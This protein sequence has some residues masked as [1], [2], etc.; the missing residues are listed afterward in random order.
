MAKSSKQIV[1]TSSIFMVMTVIYWHISYNTLND[2]F[3]SFIS[4]Y[5]ILFAFFIVLIK[6]ESNFNRLLSFAIFS[7]I[8]VLFSIPEL[9]PDFF[10]FIWDG[11]LLTNGINPYAHL[12][13]ELINKIDF[14]DSNYI[15][16]LYQ[17]M[18]DLS[19]GNYSNYPVLN[20]FLFF[21]PAL[22]FKSVY[23][24]MIGLKVIILLA[25]LGAIYF[26]K[27]ILDY[28]KL[29]IQNL[30][31]YALNPFIVIEFVGNMHFEGVMI[32]FLLGAIYFVL[33]NKWFYG[34]LMLGLSIQIK[35]IPLMLLPFFFKYLKFKKSIGFLVMTLVVFIS[36]GF[37]LWHNSVYFSNMMKSITIYFT[38]FEFN[39]S[40]F[41]IVNQYESDQ[42]GWNSTYIVGPILSKIATG[43]IIILAVFRNYK[44]PIDVFKGMLF[45]LMIYYLFATTV[46]PWYISMLLVLSVFTPYKFALIWTLLIPLTY[47]FYSHPE[48]ALDFRILEYV[49]V[50]TVLGYELIKYWK[51]DILNL[52]FK[53]F[54][55]LHKSKSKE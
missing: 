21:I 5:F 37:M 7:R 16:E 18:T 51:K 43:L 26:I 48:S 33:T 30:W 52:N 53:S 40:L 2:D 38:T 42:M 54:F 29:P 55:E 44:T 46:H 41:G 27:K 1:L 34:S 50:F 12:P 32:F 31:L 15:T 19:K 23:A 20:Q 49:L 35:L 9:S 11:E 22:F 10:R 25:D 14:L 17:G 36:I 8:L 3:F 13:K 24:N 4:Q 6:I 28:L 47:S 45:G 39:S